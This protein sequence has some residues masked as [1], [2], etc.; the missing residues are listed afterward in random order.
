MN[1]VRTAE[2]FATDWIEKINRQH[3]SEA[4]LDTLAPAERSR[5]PKGDGRKNLESSKV[6]RIDEKRFWAGKKQ[7]AD[8]IQRVQNSF[9]PGTPTF[10]LS[11]VQVMPLVRESEGRITAFFDVSLRYPDENTGKPQYVVQGQLIVT[12]QEPDTA[13]TLSS[14]RVEAIDIESGRT[15]PEE[16]ARPPMP[17]Q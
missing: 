7:R 9:Q 2:R 15:P 5:Q 6:L 14:W 11:R 8:I 10:M 3:W 1:K 12:T 16:M 13:S 4:Y 17:R